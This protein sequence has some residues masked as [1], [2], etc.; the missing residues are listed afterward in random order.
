MLTYKLFNAQHMLLS[1]TSREGLSDGDSQ[2][3][4]NPQHAL[5][6]YKK[7]KPARCWLTCCS[8]P[9]EHLYQLQTWKASKMLTYRL[10]K[11]QCIFLSATNRKA[12][13]TMTYSLFKTQSMLLSATSREG[14]P[15]ADLQAVHNP[16]NALISNQQER[17]AR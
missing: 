7:G 15:D 12:S 6:S 17:P 5:V 11:P 16:E 14:Q 3:V 1:E 10:F 2:S 8:N 13:K 4:Q 9:I